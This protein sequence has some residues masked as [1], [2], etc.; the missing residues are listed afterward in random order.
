MQRERERGGGSEADIQSAV[1]ACIIKKIISARCLQNICAHMISV[2][3]L[4]LSFNTSFCYMQD[5]DNDYDDDNDDDDYDDDD[6]D[7]DDV[8]ETND[9][10]LRLYFDV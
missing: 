2:M 7:E 1:S 9:G 8:R 6:N 4:F 5:D 10:Y 3:A